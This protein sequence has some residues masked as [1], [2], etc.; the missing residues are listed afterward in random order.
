MK[1]FIKRPVGR[2]VAATVV[3]I[4]ALS[5]AAAQAERFQMIELNEN[6]GKAYLRVDLENGAIAR[7]EQDNSVWQCTAI[8]VQ[9]S[10][11]DASLA[12]RVADLEDRV[13]QL[14]AEKLDRPDLTE[15]EDALD[16]SEKFMRRFF[17]MVQ[18]MKK[19]MAQ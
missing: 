2:L 3:T 8:E 5:A 19:D 6:G 14:E 13:A 15:L 4:F 18:D 1:S 9:S 11:A 17:G 12:G 10:G 16:T 7:C